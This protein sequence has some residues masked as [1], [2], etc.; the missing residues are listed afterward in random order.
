MSSTAFV[1]IGSLNR[2]SG[3]RLGFFDNLGQRVPVIRIAGQRLGMEKE[4]AAPAA[5]VGRRNGDLDAELMGFVRLALA[6]ALNAASESPITARGNQE[7]AEATFNPHKLKIARYWPSRQPAL[8]NSSTDNNV[9]T[10]CLSIACPFLKDSSANRPIG[11]PATMS[12]YAA[13]SCGAAAVTS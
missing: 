9:T 4:L 2:T 6:D 3:K 11:P 1:H 8:A 12:P 7:A 10:A 13:I 5:P